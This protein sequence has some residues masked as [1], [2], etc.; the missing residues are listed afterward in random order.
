ME[1]GNYILKLVIMPISRLHLLG[2]HNDF[3]RNASLHPA[4]L[5][6]FGFWQGMGD[7][8]Y[9]LE[10]PQSLSTIHN[11]FHVSQLRKCLRVP[12]EATNY[13]ALDIQP[14]LS[15]KEHPIR[16]FD[17]AERKARNKTTKFVKVQRS[18]HSEREATWEQEDQFRQSYPDLFEN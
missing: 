15:Y 9:Q 1:G 13:E 6:H 16:I 17:Q 7:V 11:V 12:I 18:R 4:M 5:V 8:A 3:K 14:N 10:L 2:A